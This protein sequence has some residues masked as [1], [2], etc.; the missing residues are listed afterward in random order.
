MVNKI[1]AKKTFKDQK[2]LSFKIKIF[3][4]HCLR[5][6]NFLSVFFS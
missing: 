4:N 2:R 3:M 6:K 1:K 5:D